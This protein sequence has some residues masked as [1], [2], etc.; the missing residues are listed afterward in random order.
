M[1]ETSISVKRTI[2]A[3]TPAVFDVLSNPNRH[4][5][6]DGSGSVVSVDTGDRIT[7]VG[8]SFRMNMNHSIQGGDYQTDNVVTGYQEN[9]LLA[10]QTAT[11]DTEPPG[12]EWVWRLEADGP[13]STTVTLTYDW[14]KVDDPALVEKIGFPLIPASDL[15]S[16]LDG[17][18]S[19][20]AG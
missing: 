9:H 20:V 2:D 7:A 10:W 13:D 5:Q 14:S 6:I 19:A 3:G 12:W 16:T 15:E 18:A 11:A 1:S 17:L 8:Q 4:P